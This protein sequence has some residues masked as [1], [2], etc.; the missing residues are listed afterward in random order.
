MDIDLEKIK[1][2]LYNKKCKISECCLHHR[3]ADTCLR[4]TLLARSSGSPQ[5]DSRSADSSLCE[6]TKLSRAPRHSPRQVS[7]PLSI[8]KPAALFEK[9]VS[10]AERARFRA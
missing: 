3:G 7:V 9:S 4:E 8:Y 2:L 1:K 10:Q 5:L 6:E